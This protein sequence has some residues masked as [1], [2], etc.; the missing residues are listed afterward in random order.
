MADPVAD[1]LKRQPVPDAVR[2]Q[3]WDAYEAAPDA[4][5]LAA[6]LK[7]LKLPQTA[8]AALW[9]M[10]EASAPK[11]QPVA[12]A[13][14]T[15]PAEPSQGV[16]GGL[17]EGAAKGVANTVIGL[18]QMAHRLPGVSTAVDAL[19]GTPGLSKAAFPAAREAVKP[20]TT[21]QKVGYGA[22][23][24][25]EFFLPTGAAGKVGQAAE[26][27]KS[28]G[29][30]LAQTDSPTAALV[31]GGITA[32]APVVINAA[33]K[34]L[35]A[36]SERVESALVKATKRDVQ[37]GFTPANVFKYKLGGTLE[38]TYTKSQD[39]L[40]ELSGKLQNTLRASKMPSTDIDVLDAW[41]RTA[42][43][44]SGTPA[45]D[46]GMN[47]A[48]QRSLD[49]ILDEL[50]PVVGNGSAVDIVTANKLKQGFGKLGAWQ[51]DPTGRT[52]TADTKAM[53][54]VANAFYDELKKEIEKKSIGPV[55]AINKE[56]SDI[57]AISNAVTRRIPVESRQNVIN[58]GDMIGIGSGNWLLSIANRVLRSGQA[59]NVMSNVGASATS[60]VTGRVGA[61]LTSQVGQ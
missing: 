58:L 35:G 25:G 6:T 43:R 1:L 4:D 49:T 41:Q 12:P 22:E 21:A 44:V 50:N 27:A 20:T 57:I 11:G 28:A 26:I 47:A 53:E 3:A 29:L 48:I 55:K 18:G 37:D 5:A 31:A 30:T 51:H 9:D 39:R 33:K 54:K 59:A 42:Q 61:A 46:V 24:M 36:L 32:A 60:P 8:K 56:I 19:Y 7:S 52:V 45:E 34:G 2:A 13:P 17:V 23:Q 16:L 10:K 14:A 40:K 38:Q 15:Q